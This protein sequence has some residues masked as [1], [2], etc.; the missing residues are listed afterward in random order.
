MAPEKAEKTFVLFWHL[1]TLSDD[2]M[3]VL[4]KLKLKFDPHLFF[5]TYGYRISIF[6]RKPINYIF[7]YI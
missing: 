7:A 2:K 4:E 5:T 1:D 6:K 3:H